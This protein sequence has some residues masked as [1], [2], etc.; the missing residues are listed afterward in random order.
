MMTMAQVY[1]DNN[2]A[3]ER[4]DSFHYRLLSSKYELSF[5]NNLITDLS[6]VKIMTFTPTVEMWWDVKLITQRKISI[7]FCIYQSKKLE[8]TVRGLWRQ[9]LFYGDEH[10]FS[11]KNGTISFSADFDLDNIEHCSLLLILFAYQ[12]R[13]S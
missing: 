8:V 10:I 5:H 11:R 6:G 2:I 13:R 9:K 1:K 4:D 12:D 7:G 3:I